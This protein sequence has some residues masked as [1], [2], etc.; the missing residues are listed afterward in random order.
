MTYRLSQTV[1]DTY[2]LPADAVANIEECGID[3]IAD[4]AR[5]RRGEVDTDSLFAECIDG[6]DDGR[7]HGWRQYVAA[8][9]AHVDAGLHTI[10]IDPE[11][12]PAGTRWDTP[13]RHQGQTVEVA[14]GGTDRQRAVWDTDAPY[15]RTIDRSVAP[16]RPGRVTYYATALVPA[17][18]YDLTTDVLGPVCVDLIEARKSAERHGKGVALQ[19]GFAKMVIV[20]ESPAGRCRTEDGG[21][22]WPS[23][24]KSMGAA[25]WT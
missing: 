16:G 3:V 12:I 4:V 24:G 20:T 14:Y 13:G 18:W 15:K 21:A 1:I 5:F 2:S 17:R 23:H 10:A 8:I 11:N 22:C 25:R 9:A 6:A 19:G 7:A